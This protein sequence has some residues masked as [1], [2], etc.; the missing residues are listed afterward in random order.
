MNARVRMKIEQGGLNNLA[1]LKSS[2][3]EQGGLLMSQDQPNSTKL[4]ESKIQI[5]N[6]QIC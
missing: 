4:T 2:S 3:S 6:S 5:V 1:E